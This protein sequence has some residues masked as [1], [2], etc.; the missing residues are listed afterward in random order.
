MHIGAR[1]L[2]YESAPLPDGVANGLIAESKTVDNEYDE[3]RPDFMK[4]ELSYSFFGAIFASLLV[5]VICFMYLNEW[6][7][8]TA[9]F[10]SVNTLL[11]V[12]YGIH[13]KNDAAEWFTVL[14]FIYGVFFVAL[15]AGSYVGFMITNASQIAALERRKLMEASL[16]SIDTRGRR[17][18]LCR[19]Y[20]RYKILSYFQWEEHGT[21]YITFMALFVWMLVGSII[22]T[23]FEDWAIGYSLLF[24]LSTI[25]TTCSLDPPCEYV[26]GQP[27]C[28]LGVAREIIL[29]VYVVIG[30]PLFTLALGQSAN[31][32]IERAVRNYE[33]NIMRSPLSN[34]EYNFAANMYG[35]D[36][37]LSLGEFT[38]LEL[39]RLRRVTIQDLD[40]INQLFRYI[41]RKNSGQIDK[42]MLAKYHLMDVADGVDSQD[43]CAYCDGQHT[44]DS[45]SG[46]D[47]FDATSSSSV[48]GLSSDEVIQAL[49]VEEDETPIKSDPT[50]DDS[51]SILSD[52]SA[53]TTREVPTSDRGHGKRSKSRRHDSHHKV[54][55]EGRSRVTIREDVINSDDVVNE[56]VRVVDEESKDVIDENVPLMRGVTNESSDGSGAG[57][58][59]TRRQVIRRLSSAQ[60]NDIVTS[61]DPLKYF[62][63][64]VK[65]RV[66]GSSVGSSRSRS[67]SRSHSPRARASSHHPGE[68]SPSSQSSYEEAKSH[69]STGTADV[70]PYAE[71]SESRQGFASRGRT[72]NVV[73]SGHGRGTRALL[74]NTGVEA[75]AAMMHKSSTHHHHAKGVVS[76]QERGRRR[77]NI[78]R[79]DESTSRKNYGSIP[80]IDRK[81]MANS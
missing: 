67:R 7:F 2:S 9:L 6:K 12:L 22:F 76:A 69:P 14:Y 62:K 72:M 73:T 81:D 48:D 38:M 30:C 46:N 37:T 39:L 77:E 56:Q 80:A 3:D 31:F 10:Y 59:T 66:K 29:T 24:A 4:Y 28:E 33:M 60:F 49:L 34:E 54:H 32:M 70:I 44:T 1:K 41:D 78:K 50:C 26:E 58:T 52:T 47:S 27:D 21:K 68:S 20:M 40:Q 43:T 63:K 45:G 35:N 16:A 57:N 53:I 71:G 61:A 19:H 51:I 75:A 15:V 8:S 65:K 5:G 79:S 74:H 13:N 25:S 36:S 23:Y 64:R 18:N 42:P 11:G 17:I 55:K